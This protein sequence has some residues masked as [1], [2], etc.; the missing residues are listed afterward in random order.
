VNA[1]LAS[2]SAAAAT[3]QI[4]ADYRVSITNAP[5]KGVYP[6]STFT[7]ILA[8]PS[9]QDA[10]KKKALHDFLVWAVTKGQG[11]TEGLGY[12]PL[13]K[14]LVQRELKDIGKLK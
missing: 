7:W 11:F 2:V 12:A 4:P 14:N 10:K 8:T 3:A 13:P 6:I 9:M 1:S 5:G